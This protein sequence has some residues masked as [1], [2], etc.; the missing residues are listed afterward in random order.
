[1]PAR[2]RPPRRSL[3]AR[4]DDALAELAALVAAMAPGELEA[5]ATQLP[6]EDLVLLEHVLAE[7]HAI[8]W[9][10][11]PAS[12]A[13]HLDPDGF[14]V[15]RYVQL[16]AD[17]F[18]DA[19]EGRTPRQ[20]WSLPGRYGKTTLLRWGLAWA[21]DRR[22]EGRSIF[23]SYGDDLA[24][25]TGAE[26]RDLLARHDDVLRAQLRKDR[27]AKD[28]WLTPS[29]GGLLAAGIRTGIT[30]YGASPGGI[31]VVDD[32]FKGWQEAHRA[33]E[34]KDIA[35][36]FKGTLR[37]R[38]DSEDVPIIVVHH[39]LHV[40]DLIGQL[41]GEAEDGTGEAWHTL[42]I[43]AIAPDPEVAA[44]A[45]RTVRPDPLGRAPG[46][47][48]EPAR[49][50][51]AAVESRHRGLGSSYLVSALEQQDPQPAEGKELLR[52]WFVLAEA[53]E[54]PRAPELAITSWDLKLKD[55]E[56]GDYVV[57]QCWWRQAGGY[58]LMDQL[59]GQYDHATTANAIAL[60]AVRN[61]Q[62]RTHH[63][64][65]AGSFDE[66]IPELRK[67]L[68]NYRVSDAM[69]E[70]L[71]MTPSERDA[72]AELR[73]RG[74]A[75]LVPNPPRG[76]KSVRARAYIAPHA[77]S[78]HVRFPADAPWVPAL[79][80]EVTAF[81][82]GLHDDQVDAMSQALQKLAKGGAVASAPSGNVRTAPPSAVRQAAPQPR[83]PRAARASAPR[84]PL[85][86][87]RPL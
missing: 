69:A 54:L 85:P 77:E 45:G 81:P 55:R 6:P 11:D 28:R 25:E 44:A 5:F 14:T 31:M 65:A 52:E 84:N 60:L 47:V 42:A 59:R 61:P 87:R 22:P 37:N 51:L 57:G 79:L 23:V 75:N 73:R 30:G 21:L 35:E 82:D 43:P 36:R 15:Y 40:D 72:V 32:P 27:R 4:Q 29:G 9:R 3:P 24:L 7:H 66:V 49:F 13:H 2:K 62:V 50:D 74:M 68:A 1:M 39:R 56:A 33:T 20:L 26:V 78:G 70:R 58:W 16:L 48:I 17:R 18:V 19:I 80:D 86:R 34:R 71:G 46:E 53:S 8:G 67:P 41:Q 12:L 76:D 64:E 10:R 38:L 83:A 63:V